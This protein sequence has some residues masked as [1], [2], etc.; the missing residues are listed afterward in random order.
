MGDAPQQSLALIMFLSTYLVVVTILYV[1]VLPTFFTNEYKEWDSQFNVTDNYM[2]L[3][4]TILA[5][6]DTFNQ[7]GLWNLLFFSPFL[8]TIGFIAIAMAWPNWL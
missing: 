2:G 4:T 1:S 7:L 8:L 5:F 3:K 6:Q